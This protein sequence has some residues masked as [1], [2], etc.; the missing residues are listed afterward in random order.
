MP[1]ARD[2]SEMYSQRGKILLVLN[3][4]KYKEQN[5]KLTS[6]ETKWICIQQ[7]C[8]AFIRILCETS[9][10]V[11]EI[12]THEPEKKMFWKVKI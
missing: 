6:G 11:N 12:H 2:L 3:N 10:R 1:S 9:D 8:N 7:I 4:F 5:Q